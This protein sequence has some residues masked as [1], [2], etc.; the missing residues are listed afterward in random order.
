MYFPFFRA[1]QHDYSA[2]LESKMDIYDNVFPIIEPLAKPSQKF[3]QYII[4]N[5]IDII[6]IVN[7]FS[8]NYNH[9][10]VAKDIE[11]F[12]DHQF[13]TLGYNISHKTS[14]KELLEVFKKYPMR[15]FALIFH[16]ENTVVENA[17]HNNSNRVDWVV[18]IDG[19]LS[20]D[21]KETYE[22]YDRILVRD[23]F[24][25]EDRNADYPPTSYYSDLYAT[26]ESDG[27]KGYGD[28]LI[29]T[30]RYKDGGGAAHAVALHLTSHDDDNYNIIMN[31][32]VSDD[33]EGA[34]NPGGKYEQA[35]KKLL[36]FLRDNPSVDITTGANQ[37]KSPS[38]PGLGIAKKRSLIHHLEYMD[39]LMIE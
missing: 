27:Y 19:K 32:F 22:E 5:K 16:S 35:R 2:I 14:V 23:C 37:F 34:Q 15:Q 33:T 24:E 11:S 7:P 29:M 1:K 9:E 13:L 28:F 4:N 18:L 10:N 30:Y 3:I 12:D 38:Y 26:Y 36:K 21:F 8:G 25:K 6:F 31:H 20:N 17:I 39:S